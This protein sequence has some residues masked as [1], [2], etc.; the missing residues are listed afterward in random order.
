[1]EKHDLS[2]GKWFK[3]YKD[4][5][6]YS[7][8]KLISFVRDAHE[9]YR[10]FWAVKFGKHLGKVSSIEPNIIIYIEVLTEDIYYDGHKL[11]EVTKAEAITA[12]REIN[13]ELVSEIFRKK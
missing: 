6:N 1:M 12:Y 3:L 10:V 7:Y 5:N 9:N 2:I 8:I 13:V 11:S 4:V